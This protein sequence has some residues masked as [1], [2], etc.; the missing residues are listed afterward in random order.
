MAWLRILVRTAIGVGMV[1]VGLGWGRMN[2]PSLDDDL[3]LT[4]TNEESVLSVRFS[5]VFNQTDLDAGFMEAVERYLESHVVMML[6]S[7]RN[8][9]VL[10]PVGDSRPDRGKPDVQSDD[11]WVSVYI[12]GLE[13]RMGPT[14]RFGI[15]SRQ[16]KSAHAVIRIRLQQPGQ[17]GIV[18]HGR[19]ESRLGAWGVLVTVERDAMRDWE[20][21][22][23]MVGLAARA[24]LRD[25]IRR[26]PPTLNSP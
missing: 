26:L 21:D 4:A 13:E 12:E 17:E 16:R 9:R 19:G 1:V 18:A 5:G 7:E 3:G 10:S 11:A 8:I 6:E 2:P 23:S 15:F 24:A 22:Q 20:L 25:A 14:V